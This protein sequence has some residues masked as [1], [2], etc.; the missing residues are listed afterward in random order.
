MK[1]KKEIEYMYD[2]CIDAVINGKAKP[3]NYY[4][5]MIEAYNYVLGTQESGYAKHRASMSAMRQLKKR[6]E[7]RS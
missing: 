7:Q 1:S 5:G 3:L 6:K 2:S 4:L